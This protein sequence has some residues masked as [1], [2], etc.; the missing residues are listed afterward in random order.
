MAANLL[1]LLVLIGAGFYRAPDKSA[2]PELP[3]ERV[4]VYFTDKGVTSDAQYRSALDAVELAAL[5]EQSRR[6]F[7][8][9]IGGFD[10]DDLPV[11]LDYV[12]RVEQLGGRL[13][14][15]SR[16]LNA[17]CFDL[18]RELHAPV[19]ALPFVFDLRPALSEVRREPAVAL[20]LRASR[21]RSQSVDTAEAHRFYGPSYDQARM[22]GVP[23]LFYSGFFGS[24]VKLAIFDT[25]LKLNNVAVTGLRVDQQHDFLSGDNLAVFLDT[26]ASPEPV[27]PEQLRYLGLAKDPVLAC[28]PDLVLLAYVADSFAYGYSPP[29]RAVYYSVSIDQ[30]G[31]WSAPGLVAL[32]QQAT[33]LSSHTFENL[34]A[35]VGPQASYLA[36]NDLKSNYRARPTS[37]VYLRYYDGTTWYDTTRLALGR[38]PALATVA[39][40]LY[41]VYVN[42][43]TLITLRK[44]N[45]ASPQ[46]AWV[47]QTTVTAPERTDQTLVAADNL[48]RVSLIC[49]TIDTGR[50]LAFHSTDAGAS[51]ANPVELA[52]NAGSAVLVSSGDGLALF[53]Q[54]FAVPVAGRVEMLYSDDLGAS[55]QPRTAPV[56]DQLAL[57]AFT[58]ASSPAGLVVYYEIGG[59]L[60]RVASADGGQAWQ[61]S[62]AV[63]SSGFACQPTAAALG[64]G[65]TTV[66]VKRGDDN[67]AWEPADTLRFSRDQPDH[68]TRM[69]SIIAGYQPGGIVGIAPG[70]D[71]MIAKTEF[72]KTASGRY[73]EYILEEDTYIEALEW[74]ERLGAD[75]VST[76]LGYRGWYADSQLDGKTAP[77][78]RA[79]ALA[80]R[81]GLVV[82]AA[83]GNRDTLT[84]PWPNPYITAPAD[85]DGIVA[86]GGVERNLLPWRGTG[87]GPTADG[88]SKPELVALSD[89]VAVAAPDSVN[90]LEGSVGTSCATALIAGA[91][92]LLKEAH[93]AWTAESLKAVLFATAT[94]APVHSCTTGF[95]VPRLDSAFGRFPPASGPAA[96]RDE[97]WAL[98]NPF[99]A[100]SDGQVRFAINLTRPTSKALLYI[101]TMSGA[102]VDTVR[103]NTAPMGRPGRYEDV[104]LLDDIGSL[105][106]GTN[107]SGSPA[108]GGMYVAVLH[109]TFGNAVTKFALVR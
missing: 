85:A 8:A 12:R 73:Y 104:A 70:V 109:T 52:S 77:I 43:D 98:P 3:T 42:D 101:Y 13:R 55:W 51:F 59:Q 35:A 36:Y 107:S 69:A 81:R 46:P 103:L 5:P 88:R 91:F 72:H 2:L 50:L 106:D 60:F 96:S 76:S 39:D 80:A 83:M 18:P 26:A 25:G 37:N 17:A 34:Q 30:G 84:Y 87:T 21:V 23:D 48:G 68:G 61:N 58:A 44:A 57:G 45:I 62:T 89:T 40:S 78:S 11:L 56:A 7:D 82:V 29:R 63:D 95:G 108:A 71:L 4:W 94:N 41:L 19:Y 99:N 1:A 97:I 10:H 75:I 27:L 53:F 86:A 22:M 20:P 74:A 16:W 31:T 90:G 65:T 92:A 24:G 33:Q 100:G 38:W 93:P 66:W 32:S 47:L 102:I 15:V 105:W 14:S 9:P 67:A 6:R 49:H 79:A 28:M 64:S 54:D